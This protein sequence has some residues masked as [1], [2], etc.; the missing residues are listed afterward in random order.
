MW[1]PLSLCPLSLCPLSHNHGAE[2]VTLGTLVSGTAP[3]PPPIERGQWLRCPRGPSG[4]RMAA[5]LCL[6]AQST[7]ALAGRG[8]FPTPPSP[9]PSFPH[10]W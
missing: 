9:T 10:K 5:L 7:G 3:C 4:K 6:P 8:S 1:E 2:G